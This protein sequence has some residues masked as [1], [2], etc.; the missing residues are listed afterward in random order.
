MRTRRPIAKSMPLL[1][2]LICFTQ[3]MAA[4]IRMYV[5]VPAFIVSVAPVDEDSRLADNSI[6][7]QRAAGE[8]E[9]LELGEGK[10]Q[11]LANGDIRFTR[12]VRVEKDGAYQFTSRPVVNGKVLEPPRPDSP[13]QAVVVVDTLPPVA[14]L[15]TPEEGFAANPGD[16]VVL[17]WSAEDENLADKPAALSYTSDGGKSWLPIQRDLPAVGDLP[18]T[19]PDRALPAVVR[20]A[21]I[22]RAGNAGRSL[23]TIEIRPA[24]VVPPELPPLA[25]PEAPRPAAVMQQ[26]KVEP[27]VIMEPVMV[28]AQPET[29]RS[30]LYYLMALNLMRQDKPA[31]A[32]QYYWLSVKEDPDFINAWADIG[33]A[34]TALGAYK[35]AREVVEQTRAKA[36][37]RI[38][39]MHLMGETY[40]AEG[41]ALLG[42]AK[43]SE[44][45]LKAKGL[46]DQAVAWYGQA[47]DKAAEDWRLSERAPSYYRLGE[48]CYYV[49]MDRDG[50]RAYWLKILELHSPT[51]NSDLI[52]WSADKD[53]AK[54][55]RRYQNYTYQKVSLDTWQ[56]WARGYLEQLDARERQGIL[57]LMPAQRITAIPTPQSLPYGGNAMNPGRDDGRSLFS[58]PA[59]LNSTGVKPIPAGQTDGQCSTMAAPSANAR[60]GKAQ[61][62]TAVSYPERATDNYSFYGRKESDGGKKTPAST[63]GARGNGR[64]LFT[65]GPDQPPPPN[66][67]PYA[68]PQRGRSQAEWTGVM[69]YGNAPS[70]EW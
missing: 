30:W 26:E 31:D 35:S 16:R 41:M 12:E 4:E 10:K 18:W 22:D 56:K 13:P 15:V 20:V 29:N 61:P 6:L 11:T 14:E 25:A 8:K 62:K 52:H 27:P 54:A 46:I 65:G 67:D 58:L 24:A 28:E 59:D 70:N 53:K 36:P 23:R 34:Y 45:R 42:R 33:L 1:A 17:A 19:I 39:L 7:Y 63:G 40:Q 69:P 2:V 57:D 68:F 3:A 44:D 60:P 9:W 48:I 5:A 51:P 55:M 50:A 37:D 38:D 21:A 43:S 66:P 47:L 32:L 49:N 64:S